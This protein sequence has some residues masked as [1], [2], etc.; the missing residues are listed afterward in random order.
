MSCHKLYIIGNGFDLAHGMRTSWGDFRNWLR[1]TGHMSLENF[2]ESVFETDLWKD[3]EN[4]LGEYELNS[5]HLDLTEGLDIDND[6]FMRD[7][8]IIEDSSDILK[9]R[10]EEL[11]K[12]FS[13][14]VKSLEMSETPF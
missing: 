3:F 12:C 14:W 8:A 5:V 4:A 10:R 6:H 13:L 7:T 1:Y 2:W 9:Q 11:V